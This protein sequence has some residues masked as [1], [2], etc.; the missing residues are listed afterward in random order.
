MTIHTRT[1]LLKTT[2]IIL[3]S[4]IITNL[5]TSSNFTSALKYSTDPITLDFSFGETLNI[6]TSGDITISNLTPGTK[7]ISSSSYVVSVNTNNITGYTLSATVG[8]SNS[9]TNYGT[10]CIDN[11]NL[12]DSNNDDDTSTNNFTMVDTSTSNTNNTG[13][14]LTPGTWGVK[15]SIVLPPKTPPLNHYRYIVL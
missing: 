4:L 9:N 6:T 5:L 2:T 15:A 3:G 1:K 8:C 7:S 13:V 10:S 14:V 12:V 11:K